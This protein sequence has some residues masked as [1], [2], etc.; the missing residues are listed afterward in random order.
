MSFK[1]FLSTPASDKGEKPS[2]LSSGHRVDKPCRQR[3]VV[4]AHRA[5]VW[6][7]CVT[8]SSW[9]RLMPVFPYGPDPIQAT[10]HLQEEGTPVL[11]VSLILIALIFSVAPISAVQPSDPLIH[12]HTVCSSRYAPSCSV[13]VSAR[14]Q[15]SVAGPPSH[16]RSH[17]PLPSRG[18][19]RTI[20]KFRACVTRGPCHPV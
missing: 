2:R 19:P 4:P 5:V 9:K 7:A 17:S 18:S 13:S 14:G 1:A 16:H 12:T 3:W 11:S 15:P 10:T 20:T 6:R 8:T